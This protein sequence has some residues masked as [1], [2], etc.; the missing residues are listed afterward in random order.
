MKSGPLY[1]LL[2]RIL[3]WCARRQVT[4]KA[5]H[6][7]TEWSLHPEVF[8]AICPKAHVDLFPPGSTINC[9]SLN[10]HF[11]TPR[12]GQWMQTWKIWTYAF[13]PAGLPMQQSHTGWV[14]LNALV[15]GPSGHVQSDPTVPAQ[16]GDSTIQPDH[17]TRICQT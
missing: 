12:H 15:L 10:H 11:Q 2:W 14:G 16:S 8:Q 3:T 17:S 1:T 5:R 7:Q 9:H 13:P 4:L 6:I